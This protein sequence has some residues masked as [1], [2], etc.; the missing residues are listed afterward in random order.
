MSCSLPWHVQPVHEVLPL[1][2]PVPVKGQIEGEAMLALQLLVRHKVPL[3]KTGKG[4][5]VSIVE[6]QVVTASF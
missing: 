6:V 2:L 5:N 4:A 3:T 1:P